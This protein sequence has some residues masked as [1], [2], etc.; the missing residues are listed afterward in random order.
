[1]KFPNI[2]SFLKSATTNINI[3]SAPAPSNWQVLTATSSTTAT[4]QT[5]SSWWVTDHNS[6]TW[7]Q[8]WA[9]WD[10]QHLTTAQV[11][12]LNNQSWTN[13]WDQTINTWI[14][15]ATAGQTVV[16]VWTHIVNSSKLTILVNWLEQTLWTDYTDTSTTSITFTSWLIVNDE[17]KYKI[18]S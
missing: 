17:V 2:A 11:T 7:I 9:I 1:M 8:G 18:L 12:K 15:T 4:W 13:T 3:A 5:P 14:I 10:Y 6:L 16:T